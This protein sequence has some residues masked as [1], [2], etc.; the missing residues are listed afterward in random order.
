MSREVNSAAE[1]QA[2]IAK[3]WKPN[4]YLSNMS[5]A[6]FSGNN[7][8]VPGSFFYWVLLYIQ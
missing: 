4:R 3:G 1:I 6:F 5:M 2:R 7:D 8:Y